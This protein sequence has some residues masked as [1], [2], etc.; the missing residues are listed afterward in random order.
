MSLID[1]PFGIVSN[2]I[3]SFVGW[4]LAFLVAF[5]TGA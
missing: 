2:A 3:E 4:T 5:H 1:Y